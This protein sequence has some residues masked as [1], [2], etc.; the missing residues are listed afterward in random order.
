MTEPHE[1]DAPQMSEPS[2]NT[3]TEP[4]TSRRR[5]ALSALRFVLQRADAGVLAR[6]RRADTRSPPPDFFRVSVE[7]LDEILPVQGPIRD[8]Q[9][10]RWAVIVQAMAIAL[11]TNP[12]DGGLLGGVPFGE[13]LARADVAEMRMLRLLE[14]REE[15]LPDLVRQ[16]VSQL[17]GKGQPFSANDVADLIL[18]GNSER[19]ERARREIARNFYRHIDS[20]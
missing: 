17:V 20:N 2:T 19:G 16:L 15:Q 3:P 4:R 1:P 11:G 8:E 12:A 14:A 7:V 5:R 6:L 9:E 18:D 13:A 10:S